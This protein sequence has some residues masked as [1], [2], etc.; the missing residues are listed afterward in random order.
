MENSVR[1]IRYYKSLLNNIEG[2]YTLDLSVVPT[3]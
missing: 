3:R 2:D 1:I